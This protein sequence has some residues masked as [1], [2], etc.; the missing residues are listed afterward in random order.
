MEFDSLWQGAGNATLAF[1]KLSS[2]NRTSQKMVSNIA[3]KGENRIPAQPI[4]SQE[5]SVVEDII[6]SVIL[7]PSLVYPTLTPF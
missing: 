4:T 5:R 2:S 1:L 7:P 3:L 6:T